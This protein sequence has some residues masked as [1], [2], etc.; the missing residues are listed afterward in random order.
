MTVAVAVRPKNAGKVALYA[1]SDGLRTAV[2][3]FEVL[4]SEKRARLHTQ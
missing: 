2:L 4:E 3:D 1:Y